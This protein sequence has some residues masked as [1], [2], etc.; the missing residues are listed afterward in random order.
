MA[1]SIVTELILG[2]LISLGFY[3]FVLVVLHNVFYDA[4]LTSGLV[5]SSLDT[6]LAL[7]I[8][9]FVISFPMFCLIGGIIHGYN[10][11]TARMGG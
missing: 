10:K 8:T 2:L 6:D 3:T 9:A 5:I 1:V 11:L 7:V 4:I